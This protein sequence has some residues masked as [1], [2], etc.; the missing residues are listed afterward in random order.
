MQTLTALL[1]RDGRL[2]EPLREGATP[3]TDVEKASFEHLPTGAQILDDADATVLD[4]KAPEEFYERT[5]AEPSLDVNGI[6]GGKPDFVNTTLVVEAHA[7]F[8]IRLA[9]GQDPDTIAAAAERLLRFLSM[10]Q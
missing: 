6:F 8:T 5:W 3:L 1:A 4:P 7:R 10:V 9:P 2:P